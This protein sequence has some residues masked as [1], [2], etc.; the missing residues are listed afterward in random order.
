LVEEVMA[1][2]DR[3]DAPVQSVQRAF[4]LLEAITRAGGEATVAALAV[5][6]GLALASAHRL[7]RT[8]VA[9]GYVRQLPSRRYALGPGLLR[10]GA[11]AHHLLGRW[12]LPCLSSVVEQLGE[13][14]NL[15]TLDRDAVVYVAQVP[16]PHPMRMFTEVGNRVAV[17]CTGVGKALLARLDEDEVRAVLARSG[18]PERTLRTITDVDHFLDE[19]RRV[20]QTGYALDDGEQEIGV[21][22]IAVAVPGSPTPLAVSISGP[23]TRLRNNVVPRVSRVLSA[24][25]Q[26]LTQELAR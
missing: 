20:R 7:L 21:R 15:A 12:A 11:T 25:A 4:G 14:A 8:L 9:S 23:A 18:M 6:T 1:S 17:H 13:T 16:S 10:L 19:L 24:A 3:D 5:E 22:C 26:T 2:E